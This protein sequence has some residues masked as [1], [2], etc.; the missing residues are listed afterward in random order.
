[1]PYYTGD[2]NEVTQSQIEAAVKERRAVIRWS[3]GNGY[4]AASLIICDIPDEAEDE[5][6]RDTRGECWSMWDEIW[7]ELASDFRSAR[8]AAAGLLKVS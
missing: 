6:E 5:A 1:M 4:N 2:G 8:K 7:S 3:H